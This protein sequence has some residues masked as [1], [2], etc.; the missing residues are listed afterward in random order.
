[1]SFLKHRCPSARRMQQQHAQ[2]LQMLGETWAETITGYCSSKDACADGTMQA[3]IEYSVHGKLL[4][5]A[6]TCGLSPKHSWC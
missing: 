5:A 4:T 1:M 6:L 2:L 3:S